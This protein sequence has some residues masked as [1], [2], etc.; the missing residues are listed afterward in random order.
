MKNIVKTLSLL[1]IFAV[2]PGA[3]A[4][5][6]RVSMVSKVSPRLPSIAG[7]ITA[8]S[9]SATTKVVNGTTA[10]TYLAD[11]DCIDN[12]T[13]C[14]KNNDTCGADFEECTNTILL[15]AKMPTCLNVLSQCSAAGRLSLFGTADLSAIATLAIKDS[16]G[17]VT[18]YTYPTASSV[19]G[20]M[21]TAAQIENRLDTD[22]C[23][24]RYTSCLRK[25][26]VCGSDFELC[27]DNKEFKKQAI[28]CES[29]L[30][31]CQAAG[32]TELF[33]S[34]SGASSLLPGAG[35]R[36][37]ELIKEGADLAVNNAVATC[38]KV[39]DQCILTACQKNPNKCIVDRPEI[40][41]RISDA[42]NGGRAVTTQDLMAISKIT[43]KRDVA[44]YIRQECQQT[45]GSNKYCYMTVMGKPVTKESVLTD[46]DNVVEVFDDMY[47]GEFG[48]FAALS[49][50]I[51]QIVDNFD[52]KLQEK[53]IETISSC[54][55]RS[56]GSGI[57]SVCYK[58]SRDTDGSVNLTKSP[59][60]YQEVK[61]ACRAIVD[62]DA[63]CQYAAVLS[64]GSLYS[65]YMNDENSVFTTL[66]PQ[67]SRTGDDPIGVVATLNSLLATSYNDAAI[68]NMKK[69]C[70]TTALACV[71]SMCG[72]DYENCYRNRTDIV[73]GTYN[74][75][76]AR[77]DR[78][79][80]KMGG[81]LDYNIV[82]GLCMN[83]VKNASI[84]T[85]H[86]KVA[87]ADW[88]EELDT[89]SWDTGT[90]RAG[91][92][93]ANTTRINRNAEDV[94]IGC[95]ISQQ[96]AQTKDNCVAYDRAE[97]NQN[98]TCEG[99]MDED[100]CL[101][102][103]PIYQSNAEYVLENAGK[104]LFQEL[105]GDVERE[106]QAI[107]NAKL[108]K[109]QN[110]CLAQN[111][112]GIRGASDNGS[113]F[114][115]VK[116]KNN[117]IPKNYNMAGLKPKEYTASNDLY[118]SF[119]RAR[120]TVTSDDRDIQAVLGDKATAYFAVGDSFACGSWI[121]QKTLEKITEAVGDRARKAAGEG[122][123]KETNALVWGT[124]APAL[125]GGAATYFGVGALQKKGLLGGSNKKELEDYQEQCSSY[126]TKAKSQLDAAKLQ[127][128]DASGIDIKSLSSVRNAM[129]YAALAKEAAK[130]AGVEESEVNG[131][132][133]TSDVCDLAQNERGDRCSTTLETMKTKLETLNAKCK[134]LKVK[135][136]ENT[137]KWVKPVATA[138]GTV[139]TGLLGF[140][141]TKS[142]LN[143]KYDSAESEAVAAWMNEIG[144]HIQC[145]LGT[146]E[147]GSYGDVISFTVE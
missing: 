116:L 138:A 34:T 83:T 6:S 11:V 61:S 110:L 39:T 139:A 129:E 88:R 33:G 104:T 73:A 78:S 52:A 146:E 70:Q 66:Y 60:S 31:R 120:I 16:N 1:S 126:I 102:T 32:K 105:L 103:E 14:I 99:V 8:N 75:G 118:G 65:G 44:N 55:M 59:K 28:A 35:S 144:E 40:L 45:I 24:K 17:E 133:F 97:P 19:L 62:V 57:G 130:K 100:G 112:G 98:G 128:N 95:A 9:N 134:T 27:T 64:K 123:A 140:G 94:L 29:T 93:D 132:T 127:K 71:K 87:A 82:I 30:A 49:D 7:F 86:L 10:T 80:N 53:C 121:D 69:Q 106:A 84:C 135:P 26:N 145:Y 113:T 90:V 122:T 96:E 63:N 119:C 67:D 81:I 125:V 79:M 147:L 20:Q 92:L 114:M 101:Y 76:S 124:V 91:W 72:K 47:S 115:W 21:I 142:V 137:N 111:N 25:E 22:Q 77:L 58:Q 15:H 50:K 13:A 36:L 2:I 74:T 37:A 108:T 3:M 23:V 18:S 48:R 85:E 43:E 143:A 46:P 109:E 42:T 68:E 136:A 5:T 41:I 56:C 141:I 107:Y 117:K 4:A 12:Y 131:I 51:N 38:N 89:Q 54:A